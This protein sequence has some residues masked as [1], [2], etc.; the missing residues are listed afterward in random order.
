MSTA[1]YG[2]VA[3]TRADAAR[4]SMRTAAVNADPAAT[5]ADR[6]RPPRLRWAPTSRT[7]VGMV[8]PRTPT[9]LQPPTPTQP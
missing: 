7:G 8:Y 2:P 9:A 4:A 3:A 5:A 1:V 6:K